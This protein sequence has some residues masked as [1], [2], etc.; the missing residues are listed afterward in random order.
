MCISDIGISEYLR[1]VENLA[2]L[3][4]NANTSVIPADP[5][6]YGVILCGTSSSAIWYSTVE[7]AASNNGVEISRNTAIFRMTREE[8]GDLVTREWFARTSTASMFTLVIELFIPRHVY[9]S[10]VAKFNRDLFGV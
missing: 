4:Q 5:S 6:R 9:D 10:G 8:Y 3:P 2:S 1:T 7:M